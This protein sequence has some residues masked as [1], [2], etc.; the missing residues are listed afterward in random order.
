MATPSFDE[1]LQL[2]PVEE[3]VFRGDTPAGAFAPSSIYGG[4]LVAQ[5]LRAA[6]LTV[7]G[8]PCHS[9]HAY[10]LRAGDPTLPVFYEIERVRDGAA[11]AVRRLTATQNGKPILQAAASFK[12]PEPGQGSHQGRMPEVPAPDD[13]RVRAEKAD[14]EKAIFHGLPVELRRITPENLPPPIGHPAIQ[15]LWFRAA[16]PFSD[17]PAMQQAVLAYISDFGL[18]STAMLPHGFAWAGVK[19][20]SASLDHALWCHRP[21][22]MRQWHLYDQHG[23]SGGDARGFGLGSIWRWDGTLVASVAQEGLMRAI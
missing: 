7:E 18:L 6:S 13:P 2:D 10:Y 21:S 15:R 12:R 1:I 17:T 11:F 23:P 3:D 20:A 4:Q 22:D 19:T 16:A 9:L 14:W 5:A 8:R